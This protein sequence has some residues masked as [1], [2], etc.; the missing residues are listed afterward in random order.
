MKEKPPFIWEVLL[1]TH[2]FVPFESIMLLSFSDAAGI[3]T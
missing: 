3:K 1:Y 2:R